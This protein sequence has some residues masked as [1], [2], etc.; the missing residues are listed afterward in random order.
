MTRL[1][2]TTLAAVLMLAGANSG[3]YA[4][5]FST[6][7]SQN[8]SISNP[9]NPDPPSFYVG[10][11]CF[12]DPEAPNCRPGATQPVCRGGHKGPNGVTIQCD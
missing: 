4:G 1:I 12:R 9:Q 3:A 10:H 11:G 2:M 7:H 8:L 6:A 5:V